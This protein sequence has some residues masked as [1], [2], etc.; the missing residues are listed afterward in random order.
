METSMNWKP[1]VVTATTP[2][3]QTV[4]I[5]VCGIWRDDYGFKTKRQ[6]N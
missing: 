2:K 6:K 3:V 5:T 4:V 1:F